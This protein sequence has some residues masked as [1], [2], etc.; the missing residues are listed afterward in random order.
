[1]QEQLPRDAEKKIS[2]PQRSQRT[3]RLKFCSTDEAQRNPGK[4]LYNDPVSLALKD[5]FLCAFVQKRFFL[6]VLCDLC[7]KDQICSPNEA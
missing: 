4:V 1:M 3:Q 2:L 5:F 6:C 7:G